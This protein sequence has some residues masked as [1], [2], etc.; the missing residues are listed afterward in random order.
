[1]GDETGGPILEV[2][3]RIV[4]HM[5]LQDQNIRGTQES[6][7]TF[8]NNLSRMQTFGA[9]TMPDDTATPSQ[10]SNWFK[11]T[12]RAPRFSGTAAIKVHERTSAQ[13]DQLDLSFGQFK[14]L[15]EDFMKA[16]RP[17]ANN[18]EKI[19]MVT[20]NLIGDAASWWDMHRRKLGVDNTYDT[21]TYNQLMED[22]KHRFVSPTVGLEM[23]E[24]LKKLNQMPNQ[25]GLSV[26]VS[27]FT[28]FVAELDP[29]TTSKQEINAYFLEGL[30]RQTKM[31]LREYPD[32]LDVD[33]DENVRRAHLFDQARS[34]CATG[35]S[36]GRDFY[37]HTP[38]NRME[39]DEINVPGG[40]PSSWRGGARRGF[41][42][43]G[44]GDN[45]GRGRGGYSGSG[46]LMR[47]PTHPKF[48]DGECHA[49]HLYG[50]QKKDCNQKESGNKQ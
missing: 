43:G 20:T 4:Q 7:V 24:A 28:R 30:L 49:C 9:N 12:I 47:R 31:R 36:R 22:M 33:L 16:V 10:Q 42:R 32:A 11:A 35:T 3:T 37:T 44:P 39:I 23:R 40:R 13:K 15:M 1:M 29:A 2:L 27:Q 6:I 18:H 21:Y 45:S 17:S 34:A 41:G 50:H 5:D 19:T 38:N 46:T 25:V 26:Y 14:T 48:F 8:V